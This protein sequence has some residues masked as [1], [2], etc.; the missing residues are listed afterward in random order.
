MF[1][2]CESLECLDISNL[3][4]MT[5]MF[6]N[7]GVKFRDTNLKLNGVCDFNSTQLSH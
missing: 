6:T 7:T 3:K 1:S 5:D 2:D 4:V